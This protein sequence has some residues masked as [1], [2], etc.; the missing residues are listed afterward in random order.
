MH[1]RATTHDEF[2]SPDSNVISDCHVGACL[3]RNVYKK[4]SYR[5]QTIA[6]K[7]HDAGL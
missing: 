3:G 1:E 6:D 4:L 2:C 7:P 5:W